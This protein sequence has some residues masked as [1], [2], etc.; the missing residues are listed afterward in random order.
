MSDP[1]SFE[2]KLHL[3]SPPTPVATKRAR[4]SRLYYDYGIAIFS[5]EETLFRI[6][7]SILAP[8]PDN[9][10]YELKPYMKDAL[11]LSGPNINKLGTS[12]EHPI[13]FPNDITIE[14]FRNLLMISSGGATANEMTDILAEINTE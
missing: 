13:V 2:K 6:P 9:E 4:D 3:Q 5:V 1:T 12:D 11:G 10:D 8:D 14:N 7:V